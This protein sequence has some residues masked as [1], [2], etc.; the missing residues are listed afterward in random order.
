MNQAISLEWVGMDSDTQNKL[1]G[2]DYTRKP[3]VAELT[4]I[5]RKADFERVFIKPK[6]DYSGSN[7]KGSRGVN[8]VFIVKCGFPYE[9]KRFTSWRSSERFFFCVNENGDILRKEKNEVLAWLSCPAE[10]MC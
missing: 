1:F 7:G 3:W 4:A 8:L 5:T 6:T 2:I 10:K 9:A